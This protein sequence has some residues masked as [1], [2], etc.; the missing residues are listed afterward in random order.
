MDR[1]IPIAIANSNTAPVNNFPPPYYSPYG[2]L[3]YQTPTYTFPP[4]SLTL[5]TPVS[6]S[7]AIATLAVQ[8][9][10]I[11]RETHLNKGVSAYIN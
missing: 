9:S 4:A 6:A 5:V 3:G 10:P 11:Y 1:D 8:S 2:Y 7:E